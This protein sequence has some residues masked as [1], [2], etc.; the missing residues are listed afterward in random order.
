[1][2]IQ[3]TLSTTV[4]IELLLI[5]VVIL[6]PT[7]TAYLVPYIMEGKGMTIKFCYWLS[8]LLKV[9][10]ISYTMGTLTL[11]I[12]PAALRQVRIYQAKHSFPWYN[13]YIYHTLHGGILHI[14]FS[15]QY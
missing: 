10:H 6:N 8:L 14:V 15:I 7:I 11:A 3:I 9:K 2:I 12:R 5:Y 13:Y 1:M 4:K